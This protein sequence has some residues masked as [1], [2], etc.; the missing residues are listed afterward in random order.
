M[1]A[2]SLTLSQ[3]GRGNKRACMMLVGG[4]MGD[5]IQRIYITTG[6]LRSSQRVGEG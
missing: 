4:S 6:L 2:L 1:M 5:A 3:V